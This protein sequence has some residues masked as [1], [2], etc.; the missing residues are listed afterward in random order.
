MGLGSGP[1]EFDSK[2]TASEMHGK[3]EV[4]VYVYFVVAFHIY[5][6]SG[7]FIFLI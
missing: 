2:W 1:T 3:K 4:I 6:L 7:S 5:R